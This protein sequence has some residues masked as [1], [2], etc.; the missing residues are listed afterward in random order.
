M[1]SLSDFL[2]IW[3]SVAIPWWAGALYLG[4]RLDDITKTLDRMTARIGNMNQFTACGKKIKSK[5]V[6]HG[7]D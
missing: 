3:C 7:N 4:K 5:K 1:F 6:I 2:I